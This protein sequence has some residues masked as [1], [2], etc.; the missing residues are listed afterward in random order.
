MLGTVLLG[1]PEV[2]APIA[3]AMVLI[4]LV[5]RLE[6]NRRPLPPSGLE[7]K[8]EFLCRVFLD[9]DVASHEEWIR[10]KPENQETKEG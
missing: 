10:R 5:K 6:G 1:G 2:V 4:T 9:C 3:G 8:K 7:W